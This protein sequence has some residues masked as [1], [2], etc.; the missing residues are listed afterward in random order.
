MKIITTYLILISF[1]LS[2]C[3]KKDTSK[4]DNTNNDTTTGGS[5]TSGTN[6]V[7]VFNGF[8]PLEQYNQWYNG[9][10]VSSP[11][12]YNTKFTLFTNAVNENQQF[13]GTS[14]NLGVITVNGRQLQYYTPLK[15]Y[16]DTTSGNNYSLQQLITL[17]S[18][19]LP[20]FTVTLQDTF[21]VY[22]SANAMQINDTLF[23]NINFDVPLTNIT[24]YDEI[25]CSI[26]PNPANGTQIVHKK[27]TSQVNQITFTPN[28]LSI[29]SNGQ[30]LYCRITLKKISTQVIGGKNFKFEVNSFNDFYLIAQ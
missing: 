23:R 4:P 17:N 24:Y 15:M 26:S 30:Q 11:V 21:P 12:L 9:S 27:F 1:L 10:N 29:Y 5:T 19:I 16:M 14:G 8:F 20:S 3:K 28:E 7:T 22:T 13:S 6:T 25:E 2:A 18:S